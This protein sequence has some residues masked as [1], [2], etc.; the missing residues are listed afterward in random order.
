MI[1]D[2]A[3]LNMQD[4][5]RRRLTGLVRHWSPLF[6]R[7]RLLVNATF[8]FHA[9]AVRLFPCR[10]KNDDSV[11]TFRACSRPVYYGGGVDSGHLVLL[12]QQEFA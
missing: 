1:L 3:T 9:E 12:H 2:K 4:C 7:A 6:S 11:Q 10:L 5:L 8:W